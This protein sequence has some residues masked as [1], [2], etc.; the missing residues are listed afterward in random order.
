MSF[1]QDIKNEDLFKSVRDWKKFLTTD[2]NCTLI[3]GESDSLDLDL[4][5]R[6]IEDWEE[7]Q[8]NYTIN[9]TEIDEALVRLNE[10]S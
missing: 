9:K 10:D 7:M 5:F 2:I 1:I 4:Y 6:P 3:S 8:K